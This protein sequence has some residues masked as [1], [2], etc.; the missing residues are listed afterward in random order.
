MTQRLFLS[1]AVSGW[2]EAV[3]RFIRPI[4]KMQN[5]SDRGDQTL[6]SDCAPSQPQ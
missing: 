1:P 3:I 4:E 5:N 2:K 6:I